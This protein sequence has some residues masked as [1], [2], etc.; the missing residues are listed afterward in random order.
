MGIEWGALKIHPMVNKQVVALKKPKVE[1][2]EPTDEELDKALELAPDVIRVYVQ[3]KIRTG[4][5]MTDM[6][7]MKRAQ[8][9]EDYLE[10]PINKVRNTTGK[11]IRFDMTEDLRFWLNK[12]LK[13]NRRAGINSIW[14][15]QTK[16]GKPYINDQ[17]ECSGFTST[18][19][20]WQRKVADKGGPRFQERKLRNKSANDVDSLSEAK[21]LLGHDS[22]K[23]TA[24][25]RNNVIR[26]SPIKK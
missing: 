18:W 20:R 23:T 15:F 26:V 2:H 11:I 21:E 16:Q 1:H 4:L 24:I 12:A 14:V 8:I 13:T 3:I 25:Y 7:L 10:I 17:F 5:R 22:E 6:L 9:H 19:Q